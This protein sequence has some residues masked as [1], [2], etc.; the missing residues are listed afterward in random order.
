M[1][2]RGLLE[3]E[4]RGELT[5]AFLEDYNHLCKKIYSHWILRMDFTEFYGCCVEKLVLRIKAFDPKRSTIGNYCYN[6][7]LNEARRVYSLEKHLT[8]SEMD[9]VLLY[10]EAPR[11]DL[12][13][14]IWKFAILAYNKG[15]YVDQEQLLADYQRKKA[16]PACTVF[17]WLRSMGRL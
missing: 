4:E 13:I 6:V 11:E 10:H 16:T 12:I 17:C 3:Y 15:I 1:E 7:I 2:N 5:K 8:P 14:D 9:D